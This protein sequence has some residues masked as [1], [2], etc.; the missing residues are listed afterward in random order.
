MKAAAVALISTHGVH[1]WDKK[2]DYHGFDCFSSGRNMFL[3]KK[4]KQD[5]TRKLEDSLFFQ[6][7][8]ED[9]GRIAFFSIAYSEYV[10]NY[11][12]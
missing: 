2:V 6:F 7:L 10:L 8:L 3:Q 1:K 5:T 9:I 12:L 11:Q 4:K